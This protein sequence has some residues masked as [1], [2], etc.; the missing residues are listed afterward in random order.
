VK[1]HIWAES[2]AGQ[3]VEGKKGRGARSGLTMGLA[4]SGQE[5]LG[6]ACETGPGAVSERSTGVACAQTA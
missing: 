2:E 3:T 5:E 1:K 4:G 6:L